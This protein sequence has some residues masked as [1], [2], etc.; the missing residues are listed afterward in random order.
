MK[1]VRKAFLVYVDLDP[2]PGTM[3]TQDSAQNVINRILQER[4]GH[5]NP[6]VSLAPESL[7]PSPFTSDESLDILRK[8]LSED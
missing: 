1:K 7:Q 8:K 5:Y 2:V 6:I 3:H 4:I